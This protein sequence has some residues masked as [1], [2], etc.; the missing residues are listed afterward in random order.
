M[1]MGEPFCAPCGDGVCGT[2]EDRCNCAADCAPTAARP[3]IRYQGTP[4]PPPTRQ[5][6]ALGNPVA[7]G[8]V[9]ALAAAVDAAVHAHDAAA[10]ARLPD[11]TAVTFDH[12][13]YRTRAPDRAMWVAYCGV[14]VGGERRGCEGLQGS[15]TP[16]LRA[17]CERY[18]DT[19]AELTRT[20]P[21]QCIEEGDGDRVLNCLRPY[22]LAAYGHDR[23]DFELDVG[24][25]SPSLAPSILALYR[26]LQLERPSARTVGR[27]DR[28]RCL[29]DLAVRD[30]APGLC[31][32][33]SNPFPPIVLPDG[34]LGDVATQP[35]CRTA[36]SR[37]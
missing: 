29:Y 4:L 18:F 5:A 25:T 34:G 35:A 13:D 3:R 28:D 9:A 37:P 8:N 21:A 7:V 19:A 10:C 11:A 26:C 33:I 32:L 2:F 12:G 24:E 17:E 20:G 23:F 16:N 31:N 14:L 15:T 1:V 27:P 36:L 22:L 30:R 6:R